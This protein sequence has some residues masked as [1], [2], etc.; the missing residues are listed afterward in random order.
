MATRD[1]SRSG[2]THTN[3]GNDMKGAKEGLSLSC[4]RCNA[5]RDAR[6]HTLYHHNKVCGMRCTSCKHT[7][8]SKIW[9][10]RCGL[11]WI[12]CPACRP[13][14]FMC[15]TPLKFKKAG[16]ANTAEAAQ[17]LWVPHA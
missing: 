6:S 14:G 4:P 2:S 11:P 16:P 17:P 7:Y 9:S 12:S 10:C 3:M 8:T 5:T 15:R 13:L 1:V